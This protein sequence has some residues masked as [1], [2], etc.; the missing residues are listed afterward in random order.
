[1]GLNKMKIQI[2]IKEQCVDVILWKWKCTHTGN[3]D[4]IKMLIQYIIGLSFII[5][6]HRQCV[7]KTMKIIECLQQV[8]F[9]LWNVT[10]QKSNLPSHTK[11]ETT[12]S[13]LDRCQI[14]CWV[15]EG[16]RTHTEMGQQRDYQLWLLDA[17]Q[18][19]CWKDLQWS[20]PISSGKWSDSCGNLKDFKNCDIGCLNY[21]S[22]LYWRTRILMISG[23]KCILWLCVFYVT[24][25]NLIFPLSL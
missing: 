3:I 5:F 9:C 1:M 14:T 7:V 25:D 17:T 20:E 18:H 12:Q 19:Y 6:W 21:C 24:F 11:F 2:Q 10:D 13:I 8:S 4:V 22:T 15:I 23:H 16:F